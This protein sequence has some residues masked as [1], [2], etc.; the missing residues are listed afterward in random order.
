MVECPICGENADYLFSS[1]DKNYRVTDRKFHLYRCQSCEAIFQHPMPDERQIKKF[2]PHEYKPHQKTAENQTTLKFRVRE[3][4]NFLRPKRF[5]TSI[6]RLLRGDP[7]NKNK[8][9]RIM[10]DSLPE[11]S[12]RHLDVGCGSGK[13][14]GDVRSKFDVR[15]S[16]GID[17]DRRAVR[18]AGQR[19]EIEAYQTDLENFEHNKKFDLISANHVLEHIP[20]PHHFVQNIRATLKEDGILLLSLP[21]TGGLG[22]KLFGASWVGFDVPRH[23]INYSTNTVSNLLQGSNFKVRDLLT[24]RIYLDSLKPLLG[25]KRHAFRIPCLGALERSL[26]LCAGAFFEGDNQIVL[27]QREEAPKDD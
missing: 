24:S 17:F 27:A 15:E 13:F 18:T 3:K 16:V 7:K 11:R 22:R 25:V 14:L 20:D 23:V 1:E 5:L 6:F 8:K 2:Y 9:I 26:R 21:N 4:L 12:I 10:A 19:T